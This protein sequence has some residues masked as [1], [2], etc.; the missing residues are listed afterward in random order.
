MVVSGA[1]GL[2]AILAIDACIHDG[3]VG[4]RDLDTKQVLPEY[5]Y[6]GLLYKKGLNDAQA[7]GAIFRNL[8]TDQVRKFTIPLVPQNRQRAFVERLKHQ[9]TTVQ[10]IMAQANAQLN[11]INLIPGA[12]LRRAFNGEL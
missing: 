1:P 7:T 8:T 10:Q 6:F 4:F 3:F 2:P 9:F 5:L 12:I 11:T